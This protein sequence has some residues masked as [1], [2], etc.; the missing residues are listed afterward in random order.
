[1]FQLFT[2]NPLFAT[3][4][5]IPYFSLPPAGWVLRPPPL[6]KQLCCAVELVNSLTIEP[7]TFNI[8]IFHSPHHSDLV[9]C[10]DFLSNL[11]SKRTLASTGVLLTHNIKLSIPHWPHDIFSSIFL[12][13]WSLYIIW[14]ISILLIFKIQAHHLFR[15]KEE[16]DEQKSLLGLY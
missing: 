2:V 14:E 11:I 4:M 15:K 10:R 1:M 8:P 5:H 3:L 13:F 7:G 12:F 9:I 16:K 6:M